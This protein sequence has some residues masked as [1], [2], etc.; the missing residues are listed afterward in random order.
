MPYP[1]DFECEQDEDCELW[2]FGEFLSLFSMNFY[3]NDT[4]EIWVMKEYKVHSSWIKTLVLYVN[5]ISTQYFTPICS[6]KSGNI[7]GTDYTARRLVMYNNKGK[8]RKHESY[9]G[10]PLGPPGQY[11]TTYTKSLLSLPSNNV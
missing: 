5:G 7:F 4:V 11:V 10:G 2:V 3:D 1:D 9:D 6:T 8:L